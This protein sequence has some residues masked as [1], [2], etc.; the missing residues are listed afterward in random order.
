LGS[1]SHRFR[2]VV[3][4]QPFFNAATFPKEQRD[5]TFPKEQRDAIPECKTAA[6]KRKTP[7]RM[8]NAEK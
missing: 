4:G 1:Y 2:P 7:H 5:A 3:V 6:G 8:P